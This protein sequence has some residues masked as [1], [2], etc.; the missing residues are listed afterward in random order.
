MEEGHICPAP[1]N[2]GGLQA[3]HHFPVFLMEFF[4]QN[5][6][7]RLRVNVSLLKITNYEYIIFSIPLHSAFIFTFIKNN[8]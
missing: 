1:A 6:E 7:L 3:S 5:G 8:F 2:A 4:L